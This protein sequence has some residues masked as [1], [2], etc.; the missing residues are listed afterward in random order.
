MQFE[1]I[2]YDT[3]AD[4]VATVTLNRPEQ[5][6]SFNRAMLDDFHRVW[7]EV[8][9]DTDVHAV[10]IRAEGRAFS[11]GL[12]V[13]DPKARANASSD[14]PFNDTDP[15]FYLG[16][17][18]NRVWKPVIS[19]IHG[20]AAGGAFYWINES[21]IVICSDD[22]EFF[23]PHVTYGM[24][25][26]L[27]PIGLR[28]RIPLGEALR[29]ALMGLDERMSAERAL[30]IGLVSEITTREDL[31]PRAHAIAAAIAAK[32]SVATQGTVRAIWDS[33]DLGRSAAMHMGLAYTQIGN[34]LGGEKELRQEA[35]RPQ[36]RAR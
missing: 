24:T 23:D 18:A 22:A 13:K 14:N 36:P 4:H 35:V 28:M 33:L 16:P 8:K 25:S 21:D 7:A 20:M 32:P 12:D 15:G 29:W 11:A 9:R 19:A 6:N 17:K 31:W 30:Q 1:A 26:A 2:R 5:L 10:V 27:E 34:P 3:G